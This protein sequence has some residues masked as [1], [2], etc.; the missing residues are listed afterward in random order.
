MLYHVTYRRNGIDHST[1]CSPAQARAFADYLARTYR[2]QACVG[3][4]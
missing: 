3:R 4:A 1:L 2:I